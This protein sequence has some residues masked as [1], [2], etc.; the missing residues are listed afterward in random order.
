MYAIEE[1]RTHNDL[2]LLKQDLQTR[3]GEQGFQS[4]LDYVSDY[5][6]FLSEEDAINTNTKQR[7]EFVFEQLHVA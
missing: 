6:E 4:F 7:L 1:T 5:M 2:I 3:F